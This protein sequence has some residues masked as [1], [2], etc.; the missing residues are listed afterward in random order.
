MTELDRR[1]FMMTGLAGLPLAAVLADAK[2]AKAV[3]GTLST[4]ELTTAEGRQVSGA[5]ALPDAA[6]APAVLL[7]HEWWGLNDQVKSV[8][9]NS[10]RYSRAVGRVVGAANR[11]GA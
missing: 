11:A 9:M 8:A 5:L 3:A 2:L 6:P 7:V 1:R 4:V 10:I